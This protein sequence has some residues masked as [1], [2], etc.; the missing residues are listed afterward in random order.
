MSFQVFDILGKEISPGDL[1]VYAY[2]TGSSAGLRIGR[3]KEKKITYKS[4][5]TSR[6]YLKIDWQAGFYLPEKPS[7]INVTP[8]VKS[9]VLKVELDGFKKD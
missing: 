5:Q 6:Y 3:V 4:G 9:H 8:N 2:S 7:L 1:I